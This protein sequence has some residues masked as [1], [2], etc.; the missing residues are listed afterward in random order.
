MAGT[1]AG[2]IR[3]VHCR[4]QALSAFRGCAV[5]EL[6]PALCDCRLLSLMVARVGLRRSAAA[7]ERTLPGSLG[8]GPF[9]AFPSTTTAIHESEVFPAKMRVQ[10]RILN[11]HGT[12]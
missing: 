2:A 9:P 7:R 4:P 8:R 3:C 5:V 10:K 11:N 6:L 12:A 1:S